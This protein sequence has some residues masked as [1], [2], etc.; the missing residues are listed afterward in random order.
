MRQIQPHSLWLGHV[1]DARDLRAVHEAGIAAL[2][3]LAANELPVPI[4]RDLAYC[5]FPIVDGMGNSRELLR[6]AI[7]VT[8]DL[9]RAGTPTLV[10]CSAGMSRTPAI[11]AAALAMITGRSPDEC[12]AE[13]ARGAP[14][15]VA[16]GLWAEIKQLVHKRI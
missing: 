14:A 8:A 9:V 4:T 6:L 2:V 7:Q 3:D 10:F 12:L 11:A 5:R 13:V 16:P 1:E 15:D